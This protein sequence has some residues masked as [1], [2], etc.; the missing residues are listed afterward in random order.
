MKIGDKILRNPYFLAPMAGYTD[1]AF[2]TLCAE[3]GAGLVT[4]EM[5]SAMGLIAC[6]GGTQ[7]LLEKGKGETTA[8]QIFGNMPDIMAECVQLPEMANFDII[9]INMGCPVPKVVNNGMGSAL[10]CNLPLASKIITAVKLHTKKPVTVKFRL[11]WNSASENFVDF[12]KMCEDS[13]A[14]GICVHGRT[15]EQMYAGKADWDKIA[16]VKKAV[17]I[18]VIGNGDIISPIDAQQKIKQ[19]GVDAVAIARGAI[20][21]PWIFAELT[22]TDFEQDP[23]KVIKQHYE[24]MLENNPPKYVVPFM[25]KQLVFYLKHAGI[26]RQI[27]AKLSIENDYEALLN[28]LEIVFAN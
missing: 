27:R 24:M 26:S 10:M 1:S 18:P 28:E 5:V 23:L 12:A 4:T 17:K 7:E 2:R 11:G 19:Y 9:D 25:R 22:N 6:S 21:N 20:G 14:D 13:G 3:A 8:V 16:Q 15:R